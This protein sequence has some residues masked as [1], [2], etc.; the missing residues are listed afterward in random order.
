MG[1]FTRPPDGGHLGQRV[2]LAMARLHTALYCMHSL[3]LVVARACIG[4]PLPLGN[5]RN[6][7]GLVYYRGSCPSV[8]KTRELSSLYI[9]QFAPI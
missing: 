9:A 8:E 5:S 1:V 3:L 4:L 7:P 2:A 6:G